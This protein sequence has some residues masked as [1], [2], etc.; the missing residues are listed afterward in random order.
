M[1]KMERELKVS[2]RRVDTKERIIGN[3]FY[4]DL[5]GKI[6]VISKGTDYEIENSSLRVYTESIL[7]KYEGSNMEESHIKR[8]HEALVDTVVKF[9]ADYDFDEVDEVDFSADGLSESIQYGE[10]T[11]STDSSLRICGYQ[12]NKKKE[13]GYSI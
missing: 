10:W 13:I 9:C 11:P 4:T 5:C 7:E 8:L 3:G 12:D 1:I 2:G 6:F